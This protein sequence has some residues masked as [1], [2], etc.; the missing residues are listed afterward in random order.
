V[1]EGLL[2]V[3]ENALLTPDLFT[4]TERRL[5]ELPSASSTRLEMAPS[6]SG[7]A[8]L[9]AHV[10]ERPLVPTGPWS[11]AA[12]GLLAAA[13]NEVGIST[14]ALTGGGERVSAAWRFWP[15]RPRVDLSVAAPAPWGGVWAVDAFG[16][17]Q[18]F[19][20]DRL[21]PQ[22]RT[23][24]GL[25]LSDWILPWMRASLR[26]GV[27]SW[28]DRGSFAAIGSGWHLASVQGRT[29]ADIDAAGWSGA[30]RFASL[31]ASAGFR[32][33][34]APTGRSIL[35]RG[36]IGSMSADAPADLWFA[37]DTGRTRAALLRAHPVIEA[38]RLSSERIARR[39]AHLSI[40][41]RQWWA[42]GTP[43]RIGA[44]AFVDSARVTRRLAAGALGDVDTGVGLRLA[45][46][47][48]G[49]VFRL[50]IAKGLADG[51]TAVSFVYEP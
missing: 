9:R 43:V 41:V 49:G 3:P 37:G 51:N 22:H 31:S 40:E 6:A 42:S 14:G 21:A 38:G 29:W 50:D 18:L 1:V 35:V 16:E 45:V 17:R 13:R 2:R 34:V 39:I 23:G 20:D 8:E 26:A 11:Y 24:G 15:K 47:G 28:R 48:I 33:A 10:V 19:S 12:I 25:T 32:S 44:A 46:P 30:R 7:I 5:R 27:E 36:G 4:L